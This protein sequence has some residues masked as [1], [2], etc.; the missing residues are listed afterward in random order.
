MKPTKDWLALLI[1]VLIAWAICILAGTASAQDTYT[2]YKIPG[3]SRVTTASG[4]VMQGYR[5]EEYKHLLIVDSELRAAD[6]QLMLRVRE[7]QELSSANYELKIAADL[8]RQESNLCNTEVKRKDVLLTSVAKE[9]IKLQN[10]LILRQRLL[11]VGGGIMG[12][13]IGGLI[14]GLVVSN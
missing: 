3:G 8:F 7:A 6:A 12:S 4:E 1:A 14:I 5:L 13:L 2:F 11:R 9:N 10:K